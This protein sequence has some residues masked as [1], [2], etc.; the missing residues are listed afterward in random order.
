MPHVIQ[1]QTSLGEVDFKEFH[2]LLIAQIFNKK[3]LFFIVKSPED[4]LSW[5]SRLSERNASTKAD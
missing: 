3:S 4:N 1:K 5:R 2:T